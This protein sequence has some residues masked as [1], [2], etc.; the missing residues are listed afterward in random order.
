MAI[1]GNMLRHELRGK[2][3]LFIHCMEVIASFDEAP[4][5]AWVRGTVDAPS[6]EAL[7]LCQ[8]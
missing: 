5:L 3:F 7:V 8:V 4:L 6:A 2:D 1:L